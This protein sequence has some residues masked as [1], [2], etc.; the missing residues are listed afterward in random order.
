MANKEN[1]KLLENT[2]DK[3]V[4]EAKDVQTYNVGILGEAI[5]ISTFNHLPIDKLEKIRFLL[6]KII[7]KKKEFKRITQNH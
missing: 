2:L 4:K 6:N 3:I 7:K 5:M 1:I